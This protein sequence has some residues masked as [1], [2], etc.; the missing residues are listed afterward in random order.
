MTESEEATGP[1]DVRPAEKSDVAGIKHVLAV[2]W[3]DSYA[4]FLSEASITA[5][6]EEWHSPQILEAEIARPSTYAGVATSTRA[7]VVGMIT[8][9]SQGNVLFVTRMYVLPDFQRRGIG[10]R[11]I[12][13]ASAAFPQTEVVRLHVEEQNP[14]GRA[15]YRKV[16][17]RE[18]ERRADDVAG[19]RL[20]VIVMERRVGSAP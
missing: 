8:A 18:V 2:T 14:K 15:F 20:N 19:A 16:G 13:A 1:V 6:T 3:R 11:M 17:F 5:V 10:K 9:H 4:S 12:N 7:G